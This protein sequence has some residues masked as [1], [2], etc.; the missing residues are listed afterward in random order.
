VREYRFLASAY[1]AAHEHEQAR[2]VIEAGLE[3]APD[4]RML[5]ADRG[6]VKAGIGDPE[7]ALADWR[8]ALELDGGD[9]GPLYS[10]AF[11]LECE[12]RLHEATEAWRS[13]LEWNQSRGFALEAEW[14]KRELERLNEKQAGV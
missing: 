2:K 7:G 4:D 3:V 13:I 9:I 6:D 10:S 1:L 11:L 8:R 12:G 5:I 14:P